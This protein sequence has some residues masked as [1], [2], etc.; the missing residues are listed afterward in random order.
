MSILSFPRTHLVLLRPFI[1]LFNTELLLLLVFLARYFEHMLIFFLK[2]CR[3]LDQSSLSIF[4]HKQLKYSFLS[5]NCFNSIL[6]I[7]YVI[8]LFSSNYFILLYDSLTLGILLVKKAINHWYDFSS[9]Q[10][11]SI[12]PVFLL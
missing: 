7:L 2:F 8:L 1:V 10:W 6:Q 3:C 5:K 12:T 4:P 9:V 11:L